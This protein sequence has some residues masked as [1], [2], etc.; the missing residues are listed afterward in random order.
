M[1]TTTKM[2]RLLLQDGQQT[3][4]KLYS[5]LTQQQKDQ[6]SLLTEQ[7]SKKFIIKPNV[8]DVYCSEIQTYN[9]GEN[10]KVFIAS[11]AAMLPQDKK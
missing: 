1:Q 6:A 10:V 8:V 9:S 2:G 7:Y 11:M 5:M 4:D 3:R